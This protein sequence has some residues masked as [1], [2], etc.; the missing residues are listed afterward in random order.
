MHSIVFLFFFPPKI[1]ILLNVLFIINCFSPNNALWSFSMP[2]TVHLQRD[3]QC[4]DGLSS[5]ILILNPLGNFS[6]SLCFHQCKNDTR[7]SIYSCFSFFSLCILKPPHVPGTVLSA[8]VYFLIYSSQR[9]MR[10]I[11]LSPFYREEHA[12]WRLCHLPKFNQSLTA[13]T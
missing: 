13:T 3:F 6:L 5:L 2:L 9:P 4:W 1:G 8:S 7:L 11:L 10:R 12:S